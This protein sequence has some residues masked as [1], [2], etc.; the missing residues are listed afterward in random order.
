M[1]II[2]IDI[3]GTKISAGLVHNRKII[4]KIKEGTKTGKKALLMQL[5]DMIKWCI[6]DIDKSRI[7]GV[8][9]GC[10]GPANYKTGL[11]INPPNLPQLRKVNIKRYVE[12]RLK[13]KTRVDNDVHV[14]AIAE[15]KFGQGRKLKN[16][17]VVAIGTGIGSGI[18]LDGRHYEGIGNAGEIGATIID[19]SKK[20]RAYGKGSLE[21]LA[22]G[23]AIVKTA[24]R[25]FGRELMAS[26][27]A[28]MA[29]KGNKRAKK[30]L[31]QAGRYIGVG[32]ANIV[33][34]YDP[35]LIILAGGVRESGSYIINAARQ[36][37]RR[38]VNH[39]ACKVVWSRLDDPGVLG[40]AA[41]FLD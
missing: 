15:Q 34:M 19:R 28:K 27:L 22:S 3:G 14:I 41:L 30:I 23:A 39:R 11:I 18:I 4:R 7:K 35:E 40:A 25:I 37:L 12:R 8:G 9:I 2:G 29:R 10:P 5:V 17:L 21:G 6:R 1:Y 16:F 36:E 24:K 31:E 38:L 33:N 13:L 20:A 26:E 32:L